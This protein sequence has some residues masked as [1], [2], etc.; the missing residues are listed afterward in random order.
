MYKDRTLDEGVHRVTVKIPTDSVHKDLAYWAALRLSA[1]DRVP[2]LIKINSLCN[3]TVMYLWLGLNAGLQSIEECCTHNQ[4]EMKH[5]D[6][7]TIN[8]SQ[9]LVA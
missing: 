2:D 4:I 5:E 9:Y 6:A 7:T 8:A 1:V 3:G